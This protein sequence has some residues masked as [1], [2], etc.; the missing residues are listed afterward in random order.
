LVALCAKIGVPANALR[1]GSI[2]KQPR[3]VQTRV[4]ARI[5]CGAGYAVLPFLP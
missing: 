5:L 2:F 4:I 3:F 1:P